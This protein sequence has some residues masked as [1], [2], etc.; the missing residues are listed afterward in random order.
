MAVAVAGAAV[1]GG[2]IS[3]LLTMFKVYVLSS[4]LGAKTV[5]T[6]FVVFPVRVTS[7]VP[8][9]RAPLAQVV[10]EMSTFVTLSETLTVYSYVVRE[11]LVVNCPSFTF[12]D[13]SQLLF[14]A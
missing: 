9:V 13:E 2:A 3:E 10:A 1:V 6:C 11:K 8:I 7:P 5:I 4:K 12:I 14:V